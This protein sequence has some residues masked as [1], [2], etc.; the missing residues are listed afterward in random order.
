MDKSMK[1]PE[2]SLPYVASIF[3]LVIILLLSLSLGY[4]IGWHNLTNLSF[5]QHQVG[6]LGFWFS[7]I[8]LG[9]YIAVILTYIPAGPMSFVC[10]AL[11]CFWTGSVLVLAAA[12][13]GATICFAIARTLGQKKL[14]VWLETKN[15]KLQIYNARL[16]K[17]G[18][19]T[20][21]ILRLIPIFPFNGLNIGLALSK[22]TTRDYIIGT[23]I[24]IIPGTAIYG[25]AGS[26][27]TKPNALSLLIA[28]GLVAALALLFPLFN[29]YIRNRQ[30]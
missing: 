28:A 16:E 25:Y 27:L 29:R 5:I 22:V 19:V 8:A 13:V 12:T 23:A 7:M 15:S 24:G 26:S 9:A 2:L 3:G 11:F 21:L 20:V 4:I 14:E 18:F 6:T 30:I 17:H 1:K 10:G